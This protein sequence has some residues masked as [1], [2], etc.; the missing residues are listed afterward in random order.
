MTVLIAD[1]RACSPKYDILSDAE[2]AQAIAEAEEQC[3]YDVWLDE[4]NRG[5]LLYTRHLIETEWLQT[6]ETAGAATAIAAGQSARPAV[7][8]KDHLD[9][10][11]YGRRF[12]DLLNYGNARVN[13]TGMVL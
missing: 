6:V 4:Q 9:E 7:S 1:V 2:I 13:S 5:I 11:V 8:S 3:P 10:S 12:K